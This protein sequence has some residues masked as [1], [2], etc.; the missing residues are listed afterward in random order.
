MSELNRLGLG[1]MI[2]ALWMPLLSEAIIVVAISGL[3]LVMG[4]VFLVH[5]R[6]V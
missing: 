6:K 2:A 3:F 4:L 5:E 1:L